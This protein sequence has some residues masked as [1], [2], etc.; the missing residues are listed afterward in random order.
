M[1]YLVY[2]IYCVVRC[3]VDLSPEDFPSRDLSAF[4]GRKGKGGRE[5]GEGEGGWLV[6]GLG[7]RPDRG[8]TI[9][10]LRIGKGREGKGRLTD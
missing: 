2:S 4:V 10:V 5:G 6:C 8:R 3:E 7:F 1:S 9:V